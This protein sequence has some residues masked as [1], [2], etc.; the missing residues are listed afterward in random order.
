M[1]VRHA[2]NKFSNS[3]TVNKRTA[4]TSFLDALHADEQEGYGRS[5]ESILNDPPTNSV[6]NNLIGQYHTFESPDWRAGKPLH[7]TNR[8]TANGW[9]GTH[10]VDLDMRKMDPKSIVTGKR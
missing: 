1:F 2:L 10:F 4:R 5:V 8:R 7:R 9:D 3:A 6:R